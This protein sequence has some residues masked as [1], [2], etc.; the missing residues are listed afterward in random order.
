MKGEELYYPEVDKQDYP[1]F[2]VVKHFIP[3]LIESKIN[4]IVPYSAV[5]NL[6]VL[7]ELGEK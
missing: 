5:R 3:Y 1:I 2:K 7:K 6:L 4:V